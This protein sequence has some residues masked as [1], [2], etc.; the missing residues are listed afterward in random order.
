MV[1]V[2]LSMIAPLW[3]DI[4]IVYATIGRCQGGLRE[5][6]RRSSNKN[7][8]LPVGGIEEMYQ[9]LGHSIRWYENALLF[10]ST[11][12]KGAKTRVVDLKGKTVT[13]R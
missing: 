10:A 4:L 9:R 5:I 13:E 8:S 11:I 3:A 2:G 6:W 1:V 12:M 7:F